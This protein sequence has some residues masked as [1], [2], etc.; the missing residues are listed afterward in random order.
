[1]SAVWMRRPRS[2]SYSASPKS[3]PTGPTTCT[4]VK[5]LA[6]SEKCTAEPPSMR[7]RCPNGVWT[8]SNAIDPTTTRLTRLRLAWRSV[9]AVVIEEWGGPEVLELREDVPMPDGQPLIEVSLA[10]VNF[11]DTHARENAYVAKYDLPLVPGTE[12]AGRLADGTR[13]AAM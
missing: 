7:S 6:A 8:A 4:S 1:M 12:V 3:S 2:A 13:V 5:K 11:A 10:G 9:R